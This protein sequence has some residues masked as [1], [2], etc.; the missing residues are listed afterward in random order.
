V[1]APRRLRGLRLTFIGLFLPLFLLLLG[2]TFLIPLLLSEPFPIHEGTVSTTT[3]DLW[4]LAAALVSF[5]AAIFGAWW[6]AE[7]GRD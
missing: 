3:Y 4:F 1:P 6:A 2:A 5:M 7:R